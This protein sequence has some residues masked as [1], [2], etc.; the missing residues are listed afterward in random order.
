MPVANILSNLPINNPDVPTLTFYT[1]APVQ[2]L[3]SVPLTLLFIMLPLG[4]MAA[5]IRKIASI[6]ARY[7]LGIYCIHVFIGVICARM[8]THFGLPGGTLAECGLIF[9]I[10]F[11]VCRLL[12]LIP[13]RFVRRSV[14]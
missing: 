8:L 7:T 10:A 1:A 13:M 9:I 5:P 2:Y 11:G 3:L 6:I 12:A 14:S 4:R